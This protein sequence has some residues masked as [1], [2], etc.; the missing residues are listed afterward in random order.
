LQELDAG[1][2]QQPRTARFVSTREQVPSGGKDV[3]EGDIFAREQPFRDGEMQVL[4]IGRCDTGEQPFARRPLSEAIPA[5]VA[6]EHA[7]RGQGIES[8]ERLDS[9]R[10][11]ER[12]AKL[13]G[14]APAVECER[15]GELEGS[16]AQL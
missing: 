12:Y 6:R 1:A 14:H 11:R 10:L 3:R 5:L 8:G 16:F 15:A 13:E 2:M 9:F 7:R 4:R